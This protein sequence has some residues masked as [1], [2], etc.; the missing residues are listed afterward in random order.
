MLRQDSWMNL[1]LSV[2]LM[3]ISFQTGSATGMTDPAQALSEQ[4]WN[5]E[6]RQAVIQVRTLA[7]KTVHVE[8]QSFG[9]AFMVSNEHALTA[10]HVVCDPSS[11]QKRPGVRLFVGG[12]GAGDGVEPSV[13]LCYLDGA[14][15]AIIKVPP[16]NAG[17]PFIE[18]G[19]Y[20]DL[21]TDPFVTIFGYGGAQPGR[22]L[23]GNAIFP[24]DNSNRVRADMSAA[25]G[26]SG[27]PVLDR[28]GRAV[29]VLSVGNT[30]TVGFIP[31]RMF[32]QQLERLSIFMPRPGK[33]VADRANL[34]VSD[35]APTD[36]AVRGMA[37]LNLGKG[38]DG[39]WIFPPSRPATRGEVQI[40]F[41]LYRSPSKAESATFA[42]EDD[43]AWT[44][45]LSSP[46]PKSG[47][48]Y[49]AVATQ[50]DDMEKAPDQYLY[51]REPR[52][53]ELTNESVRKPI[54]FDL[55][56]RP[57]YVRYHFGQAN[58]KAELLLSGR[59]WIACSGLFL[60][61]SNKVSNCSKKN[62]DMLSVVQRQIAE[63][64]DEY[65]RAFEATS[66]KE[67]DID[68]AMSIATT[69]SNFRFKTGRACR[70]VVS[71][72]AFFEKFPD[73]TSSATVIP[74]A[75]NM[76]VRCLQMPGTSA[77]AVMPWSKELETRQLAALRLIME[78]LDPYSGEPAILQPQRRAIIR[79]VVTAFELYSTKEVQVAEAARTIQANEY[80]LKMLS[81]FSG[82]FV[83]AW[84]SKQRIPQPR[85]DTS[86]IQKTI[87]DLRALISTC[88]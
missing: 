8:E 41:T 58:A 66:L 47:I 80:L 3:S 2:F 73:K 30:G 77:S 86:S 20:E 11:K 56:A 46:L 45:P 74:Q 34:P 62:P 6:R 54:V 50:L 33:V 19:A 29:G 27:A 7:A 1:F 42:T 83:N 78:L 24:L 64:E 28:A 44:M 16:L 35:T 18:L 76:I 37:R 31:L 23:K 79:E 59:E 25:F 51:R 88:Q 72:Q 4:L 21:K 71:M 52:Y 38:P 70:A 12:P 22:P 75:L 5:R 85:K 82:K 69:W 10:A 63:A 68:N 17:R 43:G 84:C 61:S 39:K 81:D 60:A 36:I 67:G 9:T 32:W 49:A 53:G 14:D 87:V 57:A 15:L 48:R 65:N 26:D 40:L 55:Y 13:V